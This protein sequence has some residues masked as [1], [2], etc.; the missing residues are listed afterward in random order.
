MASPAG[1]CM[2]N[3]SPYNNGGFH[4]MWSAYNGPQVSTDLT[5]VAALGFTSIRVPLGAIPSGAFDFPT[6]T[7]GELANLADF[8]TRAH[9]AGLTVQFMLFD[10]FPNYGLIT[11]S[12]G[13]LDAVLSAIPDPSWLHSISLQNETRFA[14]TTAYAGS[15]DAGWTDPTGG[16]TV[17]TV[18][19]GWV[20]ELT[21]YMRAHYPGVP[22]TCA[23]T[24]AV[25][26]DLQAWVTAHRGT[27]AAPDW[28]EWH[29]YSPAN[30][31]YTNLQT[32]ISI[33]GD[34]ANLFISETGFPADGTTRARLRSANY[35]QTVR[36]ACQ[37][38]NLPEPAP[39]EL[40]DE[41]ASAGNSAKLYGL[42]DGTGVIKTLGRM[43]R[44]YPPGDYVPPV[45]INGTM[46]APGPDSNGNTL[47]DTW[48]LYK[49][50]TGTQ[51]IT[52]TVDMVNA[53]QGQPTVLLTGSTGSVGTDNPPALRLSA[54]AAWPTVT[55]G[56]TY[57]FTVL[58]AGTGPTGT[59]QLAASWYSDANYSD[60]LITTDGPPITITGSF[61]LATLTTTAPPGAATCALFVRTPN[62]GGNIWAADAK[63]TSQDWGRIMR[64]NGAWLRRTT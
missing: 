35:V 5:L 8:M 36:W 59:P 10:H 12:Q 26:G 16:N 3:Y 28:Y 17:G 1:T 9:T 46:Q 15:Y 61:T 60:F 51:P 55:P 37:E 57:T 40:Y 48:D 64:H 2:V 7:G 18:A 34:P 30:Q 58:L 4:D 47:P 50:Q 27:P 49:G 24:F 44:T 41:N 54:P 14:S 6:P 19:L 38:L 22:V 63:W 39:W 25:T 42:Y 33:V 45:L 23:T 31:V 13:W 62:N 52:A 29:C 11:A 43:Y 56:A 20:A 21:Q 53:F 32:A